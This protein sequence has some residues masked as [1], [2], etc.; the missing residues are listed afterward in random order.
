MTGLPRGRIDKPANYYSAVCG[1]FIEN[2][3]DPA[4]V[5]HT[6]HNVLIEVSA[7]GCIQSGE[8]GF[9]TGTLEPLEPFESL[10]FVFDGIFHLGKTQIDVDRAQGSAQ[11]GQ[12]IHGS[13][14]DA[15]D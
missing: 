3:A 13:D 5:I 7:D 4:F 1:A 11:L 14:V 2:S 15:G 9:L 10:Q 8:E 12:N 6:I